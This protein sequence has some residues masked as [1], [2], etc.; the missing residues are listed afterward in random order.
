MGHSAKNTDLNLELRSD[1]IVHHD[2]IK[3]TVMHCET[4]RFKDIILVSE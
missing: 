1:I 4:I 3:A 2:M